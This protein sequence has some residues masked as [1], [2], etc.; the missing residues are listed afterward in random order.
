MKHRAASLR[1]QSY[2]FH[3]WARSLAYETVF[4]RFFKKFSVYSQLKRV[5]DRRT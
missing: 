1:Q 2:L 3:N 5:T 4:N